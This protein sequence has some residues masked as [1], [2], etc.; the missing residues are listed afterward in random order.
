VQN[1]KRLLASSLAL[2]CL[3]AGACARYTSTTR[4]QDGREI[5]GPVI[6]EEAY[7]AYMRGAL[8]D[9][10]KRWPQ[11][12]EA[13]D[14][15]AR[16]APASVELRVRLGRVACKLGVNRRADDEFTRAEALDAS[17][18]PLP[19][20]QA[21]CAT[22][23][24]RFRAALSFAERAQALAPEDFSGTLTL[25]RLYER[26]NQPLRAHAQL[27]SYAV[28]HPYAAPAW[29]AL[30][31]FA[32]QHPD[33]GWAALAR[34][35]VEALPAPPSAAS[36]CSTAAGVH[37]KIRSALAKGDTAS[38][39]HEAANCRVSGVSLAALAL[40][41]GRAEFALALARRALRADPNDS[42]TLAIG[43]LAAHR[44]QDDTALQQ[45]LFADR[46]LTPP[47][48]RSR[49]WTLQLLAERGFPDPPRE[50]E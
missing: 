41:A 9:A 10:E 26:T 39:Q 35:R 3:S 40:E 38:A 20:E 42:E 4:I 32:T 49:A 15:A 45:M 12:L 17:Y 47:T 46:Q 21:E 2:S 50:P 7:A 27:V 29:Q 14:E 31:S 19:R 23:R 8:A 33:P 16:Y 25:A 13:Y 48:P 37:V 30:V 1:V 24:G 5:E 18:A 6:A 44:T 22:V 28:T 34:S 11:A 36:T 43:L